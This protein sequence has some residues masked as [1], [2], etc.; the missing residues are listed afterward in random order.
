MFIAL[1]KIVVSHFLGDFVFQSKKWVESKKEK[2]IKSADLYLHSFLHGFLVLLLLWDF[3]YW[4]LALLITVTHFFIDTL[5]LYNDNGKFQWFFIDQILHFIV[6]IALWIAY[7]QP[8]IVNFI[9]QIVNSFNFWIYSLAFIFL[10][11]VSSILIQFFMQKWSDKLDDNK[12]NSLSNAGK[13]IGILERLL[14][15]IFVIMN[16]WAGVGVLFATKSIFRFGDLREAKNRKLTEY[17]LIGTFLSFGIAIVT[18][19]LVQLF[20][21]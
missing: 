17:V 10:I 6:I 5:K 21:R 11:S 9:I 20:Q 3:K 13:Y 16:N 19:I 18:A 8:P 2:K 15:F 14:I 4:S 1:F 7:F 12:D